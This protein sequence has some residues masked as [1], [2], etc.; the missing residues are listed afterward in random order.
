MLGTVIAIAANSVYGLYILCADAMYV[1]QV[2][3]LTCALW[4]P[5]ANAYGAI[6]GFVVGSMFRILGG[7]PV[8][9]FQPIIKYPGYHDE[10]G[11]LFPF[12]TFAML[13]C[14][15]TIIVVSYLTNIAFTKAVVPKKYDILKCFSALL[16]P[17][18]ILKPE[19]KDMNFAMSKE[20]PE[21][22]TF[23]GT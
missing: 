23:L 20:N 16:E 21:T 3:A 13:S 11:Q 2:P 1:I 4:V 10:L 12:K 14:G 15:F 19:I 7:E 17:K 9:S 18:D 8:L 22:E 5:I 6:S